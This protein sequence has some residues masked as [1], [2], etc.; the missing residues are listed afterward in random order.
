MSGLMVYPQP[1]F[2]MVFIG[3]E[4][5]FLILVFTGIQTHS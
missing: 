1:Y 4:G 3:D 2:S 5:D